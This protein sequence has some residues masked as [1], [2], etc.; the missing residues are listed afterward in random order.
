MQNMGKV[1]WAMLVLMGCLLSIQFAQAQWDESASV[2]FASKSAKLTWPEND[3]YAFV[4]SQ[5]HQPLGSQRVKDTDTA[6][7][8]TV[9]LSNLQMDFEINLLLSARK[10]IV[11]FY[12]KEKNS[13]LGPQLRIEVNGKSTYLAVQMDS[14]F[15]KSTRSALGKQ[16]SIKVGSENYSIISF[17][18]P[19]ELI[20]ST[21]DAIELIL[22]TT[23][24]QYGDALIEVSRL[25]FPQVNTT[26]ELN[27]IASAYPW[28]ENIGS[29]QGVF[30]FDDFDQQS[31]VERLKEKVGMQDSTW[32]NIAH[33]EYVSH[34]QAQHLVNTEG[35]TAVARF[36]PNKHLA[37][38]LD[39][40]FKQHLGYEPE[41]AYFRY[42]LKIA[43]GAKVD[44]GGKLPGFSGTYDKA[45]WGGR[46]N[47]G[48]NG[49]SARGA[50]FNATRIDQTVVLPIGSYLYD[51]SKTQKYGR[52]IPWGSELSSL[53]A[54][55][56]YA[57]EQHIKLNDPGRNNGLLEVWINGIKILQLDN[58]N[59]RTVADLK[60]EK[61][62]FNFYFGG[63]ERPTQDFAMYIDN[64][65]IASSYIGPITEK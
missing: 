61:V 32:T 50:F 24:R 52:T 60:I 42:Y 43:K 22:N 9:P 1:Q 27:G 3:F 25:V 34:Q 57:I 64:I 19:D 14:F 12:S 55:Q 45:G 7:Q 35:R 13:Q 63:T 30:Y 51:V 5:S 36:M 10:G 41:E 39:Y 44:G 62:W 37:L 40:Y 18:L 28:D 15:H 4:K 26:P 47:D 2:Q 46:R 54:D 38:N 58:L 49:W 11:G 65:V 20:E 31:L 53:V 48:T 17:S 21:P 33:L 8:V 16:P 6:R 29:H 59:F 23:D 56:W